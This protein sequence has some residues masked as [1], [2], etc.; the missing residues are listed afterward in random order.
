MVPDPPVRRLAVGFGVLAWA[1]WSW[2]WVVRWLSS[3]PDGT[4]VG[5]V[6]GPLSGGQSRPTGPRTR[7]RPVIASPRARPRRAAAGA[8]AQARDRERAEGDGH[9][10]DEAALADAAFGQTGH[11]ERDAAAVEDERRR[12]GDRSVERLV[13]DGA[14]LLEGGHRRAVCAAADV[15]RDEAETS[16]LVGRE[17]RRRRDRHDSGGRARRSTSARHRRRR[18]GRDRPQPSPA[19]WTGRFPVPRCPS[20]ERR[21]PRSAANHRSG[22]FA[23]LA[24]LMSVRGPETQKSRRRPIFPKGCPLSIF[25]AG[26]LDFRV[27]DG[28]GYGLSA[29]VTGIRCVWTCR[30]RHAAGPRWTRRAPEEIFDLGSSHGS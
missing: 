19:R 21:I 15:L 18:A 12:P 9:Q 13:E 23:A 26:E 25:G 22:P 28:N 1:P 5:G 27:R 17:D 30:Q 2:P 14:G 20:S 7:R 24:A 6:A 8:A 11:G 10:G 3:P 4:S 16:L 29:R